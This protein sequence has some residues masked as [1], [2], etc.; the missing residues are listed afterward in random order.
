MAKVI[1]IGTSHKYQCLGGG[2]DAESIEKFKRMVRL[3]CLEHGA[4]AVA[5]EMSEAAIKERRASESATQTLCR[6]IGL[7]HQLSD[8]SPELR[9]QLSICNVNDIKLKGILENWTDDHIE[10]AVRKS[11]E[12][13]ERFWLKQ[14]CALDVW[15]VVFVC[16]A[17]HCNSFVELLEANNIE[18]VIVFKDW[19]PTNPLIVGK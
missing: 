16:G 1:L 7:E 18:V 6:E 2:A 3:A 12:T 5:E 11:H 19:N 4:K 8:P 17:E 9:T 15:P 13:R 14:L 10:A